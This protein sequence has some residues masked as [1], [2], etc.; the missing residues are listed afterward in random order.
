[1]VDLAN[2]DA[3]PDGTA[4]ALDQ[5]RIAE[6]LPSLPA[7]RIEDSKLFR[8]VQ[9][10]NFKQAVKLVNEI[11]ELAEAQNHHPDICIHRWNHVRVEFYT[12]AIE[13]ISEND[14]IMAAKVDALFPN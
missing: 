1:M 2:K 6:L 8:D 11:G 10:K 7:W 13:G 14:F 9:V 3:L 4:P 12:H 5:A